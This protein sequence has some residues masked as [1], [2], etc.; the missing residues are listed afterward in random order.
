MFLYKIILWVLLMVNISRPDWVSNEEWQAKERLRRS[1]NNI[2][3]EKTFE[4]VEVFKDKAQIIKTSQKFRYITTT[5]RF[6]INNLVSIIYI[7]IRMR[8]R[9]SSFYI[10]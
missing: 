6:L 8:E 1:V 4:R 7:Y 10:F 3:K 5:I 2:I 9:E